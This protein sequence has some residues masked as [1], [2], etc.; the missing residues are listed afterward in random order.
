MTEQEWLKRQ[1]TLE[2][3]RMRSLR[4]KRE[5]EEAVKAKIRRAVTARF[6]DK[7]GRDSGMYGQGPGGDQVGGLKAGGGGA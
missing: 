6:R 1:E 2:R 5:A 4:D 3:R 7:L